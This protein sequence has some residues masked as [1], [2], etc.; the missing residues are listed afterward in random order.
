MIRQ[1]ILTR[2]DKELKNEL[3][4]FDKLNNEGK[5]E[6]FKNLFLD[7]YECNETRKKTESHEFKE[8][9]NNR[10]SKSQIKSNSKNKTAVKTK[11]HSAIAAGT[12]VLMG[13][14]PWYLYFDYKDINAWAPFF[15]HEIFISG[16]TVMLTWAIA[17]V[18][19]ARRKKK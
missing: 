2:K 16:C 19:F 13:Q 18:D 9:N 14:I 17:E 3:N 5:E 4:I 1:H 15:G 7:Y 6:A 10:K 8:K 11:L 12:I